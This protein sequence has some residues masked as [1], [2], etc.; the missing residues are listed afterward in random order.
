LLTAAGMIAA[1]LAAQF[2]HHRFFGSIK[3]VERMNTRNKG[4][5]LVE[6][7][8]V[9]VILGILAATALPRFLD[10]TQSARISAVQGFA[11]G[12]RAAVG[13]VQAR[14]F[15]TGSSGATSVTMADTTVVTVNAGSG[16]PTAA[17]A[18]I[19]VALTGCT[20]TGAGQCSGFTANAGYTTFQ[21]TNGGSGTCGVAYDGTT[22]AAT[23][24]TTGC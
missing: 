22:G 16:V 19:G 2:P 11:G 10:V 20:G 15:A 18:G 7:I 9:I 5:T 14:Y 23:A 21:P 1:R 6:L 8:V 17:V 4:F 12:I 3:G 13:T 24:T